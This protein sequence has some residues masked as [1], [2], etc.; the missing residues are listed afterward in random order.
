MFLSSLYLSVHHNVKHHIMKLLEEDF[1][2]HEEVY[3]IDSKGSLRYAGIVTFSKC[4]KTAFVLD[5]TIRYESNDK[6]QALAVDEEKRVINKKCISYLKEKFLEQFWPGS[7][8]FMGF[9]LAR[10]GLYQT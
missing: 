8:L 2:C 10:E 9:G 6:D 1:S 4:G 7:G 3:C 5:P